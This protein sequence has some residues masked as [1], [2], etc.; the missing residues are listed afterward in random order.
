LFDSSGQLNKY[1]LSFNKRI[2]Y[3]LHGVIISDPEIKA[4]GG[5]QS[6]FHQGDEKEIYICSLFAL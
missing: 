5:Q 1:F 4:G 2:L 3:T 6:I